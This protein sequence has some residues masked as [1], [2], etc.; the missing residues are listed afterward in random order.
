MG[1][2]IAYPYYFKSDR[3]F[4]QFVLIELS[5]GT[6]LSMLDVEKKHFNDVTLAKRWRD[7]ISKELGDSGSSVNKA[8]L[9]ELTN[10]Y[11]SMVG[12]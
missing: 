12:D 8:A 4:F 6:Q 10:I 7:S 11:K 9:M 1:T 3:K 2:K 5:G